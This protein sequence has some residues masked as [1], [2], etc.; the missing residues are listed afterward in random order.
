MLKVTPPAVLR[1]EMCGICG[2]CLHEVK[3]GN[4]SRMVL[5]KRG[6]RIDPAIATAFGNSWLVPDP[7][8]TL[9]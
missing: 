4:G 9:E 1:D 5:P 7:A 2:Q 6:W 3:F 8:D